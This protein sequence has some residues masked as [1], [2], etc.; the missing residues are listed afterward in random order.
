MAKYTIGVATMPRSITS[1][2]AS[3]QALGQRLRQLGAGQAAVA[4]DDD[5][6]LALG[7]RGG[8]EGLADLARDAGV[9]RAADHAADVISLED[10]FRE[11]DHGLYLDGRSARVMASDKRRYCNGK[12]RPGCAVH[13]GSVRRAD[14][15][16][17]AM[18]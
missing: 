11:R 14:C 1:T 18:R 9:Q 4:A 16:R 17:R 5:V 13:A 8:A 6:A 10:R 15:K 12:R 2:P 3:L 7:Q